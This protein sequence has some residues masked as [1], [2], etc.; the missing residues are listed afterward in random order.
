MAIQFLLLVAE[1]IITS[2][3]RFALIFFVLGNS[4][5]DV[6]NDFFYITSAVTLLITICHLGTDTL[7]IGKKIDTEGVSQIFIIRFIALQ[8]A[9]LLLFFRID[10]NSMTYIAIIF[11][12][13]GS[14][15]PIKQLNALSLVDQN[16][17][18]FDRTAPEVTCG[19]LRIIGIATEVRELEILVVLFFAPEV[20]Y[21][22]LNLTMLLKRKNNLNFR[23][24][25]IFKKKINYSILWSAV[26][27]LSLYGMQRGDILIITSNGDSL[28]TNLERLIKYQQFYDM[29]GLL[30]IACIPFIKNYIKT[31]ESPA[32]AII[33]TGLLGAFFSFATFELLKQNIYLSEKILYICDGIPLYHISIIF[34]LGIMGYTSITYLGLIQKQKLMS[35]LMI[36][37]VAFKGLCFV[38]LL[39]HENVIIYSLV[40]AAF[41]TVAFVLAANFHNHIK[42]AS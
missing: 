29:A 31:D 15:L 35:I 28:T 21:G 14:S 37:C 26:F 30:A 7:I 13:I 23:N 39:K 42:S 34:G 17:I 16:K 11:T 32:L 8:F 25:I 1:K 10:A 5:K 3:T 20:L 40:S 19:I 24:L 2:G 6:A 4:A 27:V 36:A 38:L 18:F 12:L 41:F 33:Y 22:I 9:I